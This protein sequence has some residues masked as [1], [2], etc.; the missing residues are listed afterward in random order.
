MKPGQRCI[1]PI[2]GQSGFSLV[3]VML[4]TGMM[5]TMGLAIA[6]VYTEMG[7]QL[8]LANRNLEQ[9]RQSLRVESMMRNNFILCSQLVTGKTFNLNKGPLDNTISLSSIHDKDNKVIYRSASLPPNPAVADGMEVQEIKV[10]PQEEDKKLKVSGDSLY[11]E[12]YLTDL[13]KP[14]RVASRPQGIQIELKLDPLTPVNAKAVL[15]CSNGSTNMAVGADPQKSCETLGGSYNASTT[16]CERLP[17]TIAAN[18]PN[19][20][21][22]CSTGQVAVGVNCSNGLG[23]YTICS[24]GSCV[25]Q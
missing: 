7:K 20:Q 24:G 4:A 18:A 2:G 21:G 3:E 22:K 17:G 9:I 8:D 23:G 15:S 6:T 25:W 12:L 11:A 5:L 13:I 1:C 16:K 14:G 10:V 19:Q